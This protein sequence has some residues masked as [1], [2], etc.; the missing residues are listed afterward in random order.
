L[1]R[2][3]AEI[4]CGASFSP[5]HLDPGVAVVGGDDLVGHQADVLLHFLLGELAAD[6]ALHR[7]DRVLRVGH[8]LALRRSADEDLAA[9]LVRDDRRRRAR[10]L[11]VL[12]HLGRVAFHDRDARVRGAEV[13]ADDLGHVVLRNV[14]IRWVRGAAARRAFK[15]VR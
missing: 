14:W 15:L 12:D 7:V 13:D 6:E 2:I 11:A 9:V 5:R 3:S 10:A 4:C 1:R 8:R